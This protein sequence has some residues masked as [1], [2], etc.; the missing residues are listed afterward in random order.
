MGPTERCAGSLGVLPA[1]DWDR[2]TAA[3]AA[4]TSAFFNSRDRQLHQRE[5]AARSAVGRE[6]H[7]DIRGGCEGCAQTGNAALRC[8]FTAHTQRMQHRQYIAAR[9]I[10][11]QSR[12]WVRAGS[13]GVLRAYSGSC[14]SSV[15]CAVS[16]C[17][18]AAEHNPCVAFPSSTRTAA[19]VSAV[20]SCGNVTFAAGVVHV[21]VHS[22]KHHACS[23]DRRWC[24]VCTDNQAQA[25]PFGWHR[26][27][28]ATPASFCVHVMV[29]AWR[30]DCRRQTKSP[31][32]ST[33]CCQSQLWC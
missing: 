5:G 25:K 12:L 2:Q 26:P 14:A 23:P 27:Q 6:Q 19:C 8:T 9:D 22:C 11:C 3:A 15:L 17:Q 32:F 10:C 28:A 20:L 29:H 33:D 24:S 21:L 18:P 4:V 7:A 30:C 1:Q 13:L 16:V 31:N